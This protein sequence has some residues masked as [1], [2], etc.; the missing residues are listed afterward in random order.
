VVATSTTGE[1]GK[2]VHPEIAMFALFP[3][4]SRTSMA[5]SPTCMPKI[6]GKDTLPVVLVCG[7]VAPTKIG[8]A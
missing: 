4:V 2:E 1:P 3:E 7:T 5:R 6:H 8:A